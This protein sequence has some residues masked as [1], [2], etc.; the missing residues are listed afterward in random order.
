MVQFRHVTL[1]L[2]VL[3]GLWAL[4]P[5]KDE[6]ARGGADAGASRATGHRP[7]VI[8]VAPGFYMPGKRI[9]PGDPPLKAFREVGDAFERLYPDTRVE[10][11]DVPL[12]QREWIVTQLAG[13]QA[14]EIVNLNVED[15]WQ[16][17]QK[18]WYV[19]LDRYLEAPTPFVKDHRQWWDAFRYQD[20]SRS[21][22]APDG[23][24]Y[25]VTLDMIETGIFYNKTLFR[26]LGL[27][28]PKDW[29]EFLRLQSKIQ[30]AGYVPMLAN[31]GSL[32][33]WGVDL[34][35]DQ[36][37]R[38][39][40]PTLDVRDD[41]KRD[42]FYKGYLDWDEI[43]YLHRKRGFF[44]KGDPRWRETFRL[45][46]EWRRFM[47]KDLGATDMTKEF[48]QGNGAMIW[49]SS[50]FV[51]KLMSDPQRKFEWGMFYLPPMTASTSRFALGVRQCIIGEAATQFSVTNSAYTDTGDPDTSK[52]LDRC[53][54]FLQ[55]ATTPH[56]CDRI[57]NEITALMPNVTGVPTKPELE[58]FVRNLE[59]HPYTTTK[60]M[61]TFDLRFSEIMS[62]MFYLYLVG[63]ISEDEFLDWMQKNLDTATATVIRRKS[64]DLEPLD[65]S[66]RRLAPLRQGM[67]ELPN[68]AR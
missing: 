53:V 30:R 2:V 31:V 21:K 1:A 19:P 42:M 13:G 24:M 63:G 35:F 66:W 62:R 52:K 28:P 65:A 18:G 50:L 49:E 58:P 38:G 64:L 51:Q 48:I 33:D 56:N 10:F 55:F 32:C 36:L 15:V 37:Y 5:P 47:P 39:I 27:S 60:W 26:R 16:D 12:G 8:R 54:R 3:A 59:D 14:P 68:E 4:R 22:A 23:K 44:S 46:K 40:R 41:K 20:I 43:A 6:A 7:Y 67:K 17:V 9:N 45:L 25:C 11:L 57:V 29:D 34:I 61:F